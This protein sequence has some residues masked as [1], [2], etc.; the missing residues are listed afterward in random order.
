MPDNRA[1][2]Q[3][4]FDELSTGNSRALIELFADDVTW[5]VMGHTPWSRTYRGKAA[6]L[7]DLLRP[8]GA[9]LSTRYQ[10]SAERIIADG[11]YVVVEARGQATTQHGLPYN[12]EYCFIYRFE[13]DRVKE[14]TEYLDTELVTKALV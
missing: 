3:H 1:R 7:A 4:A 8:L 6:V 12:N 9:R 11:D 5:K 2:I 14:V 13:N 10:A